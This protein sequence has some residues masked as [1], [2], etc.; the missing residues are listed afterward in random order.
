LTAVATLGLIGAGGLVTSH[1]VG[2]AVPDWP[3]TYGYNLFAFP[4][5]QWLG[6]IFYE[7]THRLAAALVGLLTAVLALW[8]WVRETRPPGRW[9]GAAAVGGVLLL[10]GVRRVPVYLALAALAPV[11]VAVGLYR[12]W[13]RPGTLRWWGLIAL[14]AVVL[15]GVLGG[16]RVVWLRDQLG[17]FHAALAQA[18]FALTCL[19]ALLTSRP[20]LGRNRGCRI[21]APEADPGG[22]GLSRLLLAT[23]GLIFLQLVLGA[24]MRHQHAGLAIPDFPLAYG[25]LWPA[26]DPAAIERYNQRRLEVVSLNPITAAQVRLQMVHRLAAGLVLAG[27]AAGAGL[28]RRRLPPGHAVR[29][30]TAAWLGL[31]LAQLLLGAATVWSNKAADLATAHVMVGALLLALGLI[32]SIISATP[33]V[34][35]RAEFAGAP[36]A[37][38]MT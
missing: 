34:L 11:V 8:L 29:R 17:I 14:A 2:L 24:T 27:V 12:Q 18:F 22:A 33:P 25:R 26:T 19:I 20:W 13:R 9:L 32:V 37:N 5:S 28:A 15:Q 10:L 21:P 7:H 23:T 6:G 1:G 38:V 36:A 4:V 3:N 30:L 16:L 31:V 35:T